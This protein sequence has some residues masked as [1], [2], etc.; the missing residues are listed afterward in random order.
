MSEIQ[1]QTIE[2]KIFREEDRKTVA[3]ILFSNGYTVRQGKRLKSPT[4]K[5]V[6]YL[7]VVTDRT[8]V[9]VSK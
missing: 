6:E 9:M 3:S 8:G 4:G 2:L 7:V 1:Q 5:T